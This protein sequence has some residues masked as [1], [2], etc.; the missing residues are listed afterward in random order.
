MTVQRDAEFAFTDMEFEH[1]R[2]MIYQ[3]AGIVLNSCKKQMAY[4]RLVRRIRQLRLG[5]F[6]EYLAYLEDDKEGEE[7][8]AFV[9]AL[10][11]NLTSFFRENHHFSD[12]AA[13]ATQWY[14]RHGQIRVWCAA[15]STGEEPYS[16]AMTLVEALP[17][18]QAAISILASDLDTQVLETAQNGIYPLDRLEGVSAE[19]RSRFFYRGKGQNQGLARV[20]PALTSLIRFRQINLLDAHWPIDGNL[21]AIFCR[22]VMI[23]FDKPTQ[24]KLVDRFRPLIL[25]D[26]RLFVGHSENIGHLSDSWRSC[27]RTVFAPQVQA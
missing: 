18:K 27:G 12:L 14:Q 9:N 17:G 26:G 24:K 13:M 6:S 15:A 4:T 8:Q 22:N 5:G 20:D 7:W 25:D 3:H 1:V 23:Y 19:R 2:H 21:N 16:I 11:T 10:T